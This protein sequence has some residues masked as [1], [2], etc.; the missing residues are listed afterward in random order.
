MKLR[1][2]LSGAVG[3]GVGFVLGGMT[4]ALVAGDMIRR[5]MGQSAAALAGDASFDG[6][7]SESLQRKTMKSF[8]SANA[9]DDEGGSRGGGGRAEPP[10]AAAPVAEMAAPPEPE[11]EEAPGDAVGGKDGAAAAP[12]R[13]WFPETFLFEPLVVTDA[14]GQATV[15]VRVPD[16]L[17]QWRVLALA[18]SRSG[19]QAGAVT[20][21]A[22]T[23]P[24]YVDPCCRPSCARVT[25]CACRCRW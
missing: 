19:A 21:F 22:G 14:N 23:L 25:P 9:Y 2:W 18:H 16:R 7:A 4:L 5:S 15:P 20:S 11:M 10:K 6:M 13:A 1:S 24:T 12:T 8:G 3:L 17:T